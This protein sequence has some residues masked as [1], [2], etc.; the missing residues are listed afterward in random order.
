M[1]VLAKGLLLLVSSALLFN[2]TW[3]LA[4]PPVA[5]LNGQLVQGSLIF[6]QTA[7]GSEVYFNQQLLPLTSDGRFVFGVGRDAAAEQQLRIVQG[8]VEH[9][10]PFHIAKREYVIQRVNGVAQKYVSPPAEVTARIAQDAK[11]VREVRRTQSTLPYIFTTPV[12]PATGP[13]SGVYGSQRIFNGEP[14]NPH[15]GL[16]IAAVV[17]SPVFAPL[18]GKVLLAADLY[19]SGLTIILDHGYGITSTYMHLSKLDVAPGDTVI[20][21]A[22]MAEI[23]ATGR[24]TGPHLDWRINWVQERLDPATLPGLPLPH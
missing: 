15:Y 22:K 14:R 21:G 19:Y 4:K 12:M 10:Q 9:L 3:A 18:S 17:G 23:G 16:D 1:K 8:G 6:G 11:Q 13:V 20:Q 24:V 5:K 7:P 2:S